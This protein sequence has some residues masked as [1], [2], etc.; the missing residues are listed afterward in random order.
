MNK[1]I[2]YCVM[3]A[4][5]VVLFASLLIPII[6]QSMET[7]DKYTNDGLLRMERV[8]EDAVIN[9]SWDHTDPYNFTVNDVKVP[10]P[11]T[12]PTYVSLTVTGGNNDFMIRYIPNDN[13]YGTYL[14]VFS[15]NNANVSAGTVDGKD[16]T[17]TINNGSI[18]VTNGTYTNTATFNDYFFI[19]AVD[20]SYI[21][22]SA[23]TSVMVLDDSEIYGL[24]RTWFVSQSSNINFEMNGTIKDGFD[25]DYFGTAL[26]PEIT[27]I[28]TVASKVAGYKNL[29]KFDAIT[30]NCTINDNTDLVRYSQVIVPYEVTAE[31]AIH[32]DDSTRAIIG[33]IPL[34][35][36]VGLVAGIVGVIAIRRNA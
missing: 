27:D 29:E 34:I 12:L 4:V 9:A 31:R 2:Q 7:S 23:N 5:G 22:K 33:V 10:L 15:G 19:P 3:V 18:S 1:L 8:G 28:N 13:T 14:T 32:A 26:S 24:G 11:Q 25:V 36:I 35:V 30:F 21:M 16:L 17:L 6:N 20:G